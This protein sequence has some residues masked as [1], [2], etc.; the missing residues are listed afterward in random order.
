MAWECAKD[1]A[2]VR[3]LQGLVFLLFFILIVKLFWDVFMIVAVAVISQEVCCCITALGVKLVI[4][5]LSLFFS[6]MFVCFLFPAGVGVPRRDAVLLPGLWPEGGHQ[7]HPRVQ[8]R[9]LPLRDRDA[10][11]EVP[12]GHED[13]VHPRVRALRD[14]REWRW[15]SVLLRIS[16]SALLPFV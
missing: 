14:P 7:V 3:K 1:L 8:Q 6:L 15:G 16:P 4:V 11:R 13:A 10:G 9:Q 12:A 2:V 5:Y